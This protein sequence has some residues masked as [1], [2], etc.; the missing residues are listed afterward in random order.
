MTEMTRKRISEILRIAFDL[1]WF[2]PQGL[3]LREILDHMRTNYHLTEEELEPFS[4]APR[5]PRYE[6]IVRVGSIALAKAGWLA[7]SS[8][9]KWEIT[10]AGRRES[11]QYS[12]AED[13]F[14][15]AVR[16]YEEWKDRQSARKGRFDF[17][18]VERAEERAREQIQRYIE[19][20]QLSELRSLVADLMR[21]LGFYVIWTA[22]A[23]QLEGQVH[24]IV[25]KDPIGLGSGRIMIHINHAGQA[26]TVE[27]LHAF[28]ACMREADNGVFISLSGFTNHARQEAY[29]DAQANIRLIDLD[30]FIELWLSNLQKISPEARQRLPL[31]AVYFLA[32]PDV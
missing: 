26:A 9:G 11:R 12:N 31:K 19:S 25:G 28:K 22:P 18:A 23:E 5:Y 6:V 15:M 16:D 13:F 17:L 30:E 8:K 24:L 4:F 14:V 10:E 21:G 7:K 32:Q 3:Y 2:E 1:L 29:A 20:M 27:G